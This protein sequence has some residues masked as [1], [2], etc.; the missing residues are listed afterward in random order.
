MQSYS[1]GGS[2]VPN[3]SLLKDSGIKVNRGVIIDEYCRTNVENIYAAG[4]VAEGIDG[5]T[6][7]YAVNA[8]WPNAVE[9]GTIA[10]LNMAGKTPPVA[11]NCDS[12]LFPYLVLHAP[13]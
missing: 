5:L 3:I 6:G 12:M 11:A 1:A 13:L 4:D 10:G 8:T 2:V 9:Q 7:E